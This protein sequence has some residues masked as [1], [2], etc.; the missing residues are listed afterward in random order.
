MVVIPN[1]VARFWANGVRD[2]L[3]GG[4][5]IRSLS[6]MITSRFSCRRPVSARRVVSSFAKTAERDAALLQLREPFHNFLVL[7]LPFGQ[8]RF[9]AANNFRGRTAAKRIVGEPLFF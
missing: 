1:R 4:T 2:L 9:Q 7:D 3:C 5:G 8:R 6:R